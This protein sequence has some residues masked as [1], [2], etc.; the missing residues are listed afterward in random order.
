MSQGFKNILGNHSEYL[1]TCHHA[2]IYMAAE[3]L[4]KTRVLFLLLIAQSHMLYVTVHNTFWNEEDLRSIIVWFPDI[5]WIDT[6]GSHIFPVSTKSS[7]S[8][9]GYRFCLCLEQKSSIWCVKI[10]DLTIIITH[11]RIEK[12]HYLNKNIFLF[13]NLMLRPLKLRTLIAEISNQNATSWSH[14]HVHILI[15]VKVPAIHAPNN[16]MSYSACDQ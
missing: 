13:L 15:Q 16:S 6:W 3:S 10:M 11:I 7:T 2:F 4:E 14:F 9:H 5:F 12:F 8:H 1:K